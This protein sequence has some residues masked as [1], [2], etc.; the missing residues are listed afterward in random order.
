MIG[1]RD[2]EQALRIVAPALR[3]TPIETF[4]GLDVWAG[5][6]LVLKP[7]HRQRTGSFKVRGALN[8]VAQ[9]G[10]GDFAVA[11]S[12]GNHAQGVAF[13][14]TRC[15]ARADVFMPVEAALPKVDA[16]RSYGATVHLVSGSV[17]DC[18]EAAMAY[19]AQC[20]GTYVAPFADP[21]VVA[22]QGTLGLELASELPQDV[23][24]VVVPIGGGGLIGGVATALR[25]L[26]PEI[27]IIGVQPVGA[28][29]MRA[30]LDAGRLAEIT[31]VQTIA[32]GLAVKMPSK[33]TFDLVREHVHDVVTVDD[34]AIARAMVAL[35]E[36]AK[37]VV[38]PAG[39]IGVAAV[40]EGLIPGDEP[41]GVVLSGG[42]VDPLVLTKL[43]DHGLAAAGRHL[44]LR[45][46]V[47]D[48]P[49]SLAAL[50]GAVADMGLNVITVEH[51]RAA[52]GVPVNFAEVMMHVET[53][54]AEHRGEV[55]SAL[56]ERGFH[57]EAMPVTD[58]HPV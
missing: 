11:A 2:I 53:R 47:S 54:N 21:L 46:V 15:G 1:I 3:A 19:A 55:V 9:L 33:L 17:D 5:R 24:R 18:I 38:E 23:R 30:S 6:R 37:A 49:G 34:G 45:C 58:L 10:P 26:R 43:I 48:K 8:C 12:A 31:H 22:G 7:E 25:A 36:R 56:A 14:A 4:D 44:R 28:A 35:I 50:T 52:S 13:A 39:A 57:I 16:T 41:V 27:E 20:G 29:A 42:N 51:H 40:V 32:D